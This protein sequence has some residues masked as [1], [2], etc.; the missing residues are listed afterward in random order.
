M[1]LTKLLELSYLDFF[2]LTVLGFLGLYFFFTSVAYLIFVRQKSFTPYQEKTFRPGQI[3][4]EIQRSMV[5]ILMFGLTAFWMRWALENGVYHLQ[6]SFSWGL[7]AGEVFGLFLWNELYFYLVHRCYHLKPFYKFHL[8]HHYSTVPSP[9]SAYS[10]HWSEGLLLGAVMPFAMFFHDFQFVSIL[11][12]PLMSILMNVLGH[13]NVDFFP[14]LPMKH[15]L[16]FSKRHSE[17][18]RMPHKN[19][20]FFLPF[21]DQWFGTSSESR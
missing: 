6:F 13:S 20:G 8:D 1:N 9:F 21:L 7:F 18:H 10:F 2:V 12:L 16:S 15:L 17:H 4:V 3:K 14:K 5:S 11:L 19:F